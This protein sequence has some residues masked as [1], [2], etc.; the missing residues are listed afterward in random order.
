MLPV[1]HEGTKPSAPASQ[2]AFA[3]IPMV[4]DGTGEVLPF[5]WPHGNGRHGRKKK[6][7]SETLDL[8]FRDGTERRSEG[9]HRHDG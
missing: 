7:T 4:G 3:P 8:R 9:L 1:R 2:R 6:G 5:T